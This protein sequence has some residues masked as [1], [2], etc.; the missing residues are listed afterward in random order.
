MSYFKNKNIAITGGTGILCKTLARFLVQQGANVAVLSRGEEAGK[1]VEKELSEYEGQI[2]FIRCDVLDEDSVQSAKEEFNQIFGKCDIL[3]NGAGGNNP[4]ASTTFETHIEATK[5]G[6]GFQDLDLKSFS[7]AMDLNF[8]GTVIP[9]QIFVEDMVES[10]SGTI[11]NISSMSAFSPM[12]KVPAYSAGKA[13]I[14]NF[15]QWLAVYYGE[16]NIRVNAIAPGF[17]ITKQNY[18]LLIDSEGE[19]TARA[20]KIL[21]NT[22]MNRFGKP[23]D[24]IGPVKWLLNDEESEFVT[25]IVVPIDGGFMAYSGV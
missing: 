5:Q 21:N 8:M 16:A 4:K 13:S 19:Y 9:T 3:L 15:T 18:D 24:L 2:R 23:E 20:K 12:T 22:P 10:G 7:K 1:E 11:L 25:G 14:N 6:Q 17:F